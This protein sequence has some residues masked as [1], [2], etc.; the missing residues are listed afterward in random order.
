MGSLDDMRG[1]GEIGLAD[2]ERDDV[3]TGGL[4]GARPVGDRDRAGDRTGHQRSEATNL[5]IRVQA[6]SR[7]AVSSA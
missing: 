5:A 4:Q 7:L 6:S 2:G 3:V 1:R